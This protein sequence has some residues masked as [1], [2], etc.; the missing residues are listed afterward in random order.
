MSIKERLDIKAILNKYK[1]TEVTKDVKIK[2]I[3]TLIVCAL[4]LAGFIALYLT[5]GKEL[6]EIVK[7]ADNFKLWLSGFGGMDKVVFVA[8]RAFQTVIK[9][10][11][12]EP[13]EIGSGYAYGTWGGLGLCLLGSVLGSIA[14]IF[15]ARVFGTKV[16]SLFVSMD[17]INSLDLFKDKNKIGGTLFILYLIPSTPKDV[18]TYVAGLTKMNVPMFLI[19]SSIARIPSIITSTWCGSSLGDKNYVKSIIIFVATAVVGGIGLLIY[20]KLSNKNKQ[21]KAAEA[22]AEIE[23]PAE[24]EA[25]QE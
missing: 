1:N 12:A 7:D 18:F 15:I 13:L 10:I 20:N 3:A 6:L 2:R 21:A 14:I 17:K 19:L 25:A 4:M 24:G 5:K 16:V 22:P 8:I 23:A 11:P 9:I